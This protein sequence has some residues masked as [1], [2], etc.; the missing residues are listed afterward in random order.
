MKK[1]IILSLNLTILSSSVYA[2]WP[3]FTYPDIPLLLK[4]DNL[5][6][7]GCRNGEARLTANSAISISEYN[8]EGYCPDWQ[9]ISRS[10]GLCHLISEVKFLGYRFSYFPNDRD[11]DYSTVTASYGSKTTGV[12]YFEYILTTP[13]SEL[14]YCAI[15]KKGTD[16]VSC[17]N[18]Y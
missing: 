14:W 9:W 4:L 12:P 6:T 5:N 7:N 18:D 8:C 15:Y 3:M 17:A 11:W 16:I 13:A 10:D 2:S 1:I